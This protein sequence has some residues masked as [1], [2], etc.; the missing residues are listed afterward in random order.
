MGKYLIFDLETEVVEARKRK[1]SCFISEN[2]IVARGWK[3]QGDLQC[4]WEYFHNAFTSEKAHLKIGPE[5]TML[6]GFNLKFD[7][8]W[9]M[10]RGNP[11]L[12]EFYKRGGKIWD[13]QYAE[14]LIEGQT[15]ASQMC[16]LD[17]IV[18]KYGGRKKIDQVKILW[19]AG[20]KTAD[21]P[22]D[23]LI[24]YLVGTE[25]ELRNSGDIGNTELIFLAQVQIAAKQ[26]Q[27]KMI[28]DRMD[29][30]LATTEME[31][32]GIK[33]DIPVM[34]ARLKVLEADLKVRDE[35]LNAFIPKLDFDFSWG[36]PTHKS[37]LIFGGTIKY[38]LQRPY[39]DETGA[40]A[41][42]KTTAQWPLVAGRAISPEDFAANGWDQDTYSSGVKKGQPKFKKVDVEGPLKVK[43]QDYFYTFPGVTE[44]KPEWKLALTDGKGGPLYSTSEEVTDEITI[45]DIPFLKAMGA[46]QSLDKEIGT[47]YVRIHPKKKIPVGMLAVVQP[48][49]HILHHKLNHTL[50]VTTRLS[51]SEPNM[52]NI[53]QT[54]KSEVK[55]GFVSRFTK[56][57][58][59]KYGI[60]YIETDDGIKVGVMIEA[61]YSQLEVVVQGVL[62]GD[63]ALCA[64]LRAK[65]DFHCKRVSAKYG[66]TYED[67]LLWCKDENFPDYKLW[68]NR[69]TGV[70]EF[71]FQRAYG[72]G[73]AAIAH[74]TGIPVED[75]KAM[76]EAEEILY[77]GV[78]NFNSRVDKV[79]TLSSVPFQKCNKEGKWSTYHRGK[80]VSPTG[81]IYTFETHDAPAFLRKRGIQDSY[82]PPE[83]KNYPV[84]G[85][86]GEFVQAILGLLWRKFI[87]TDNYG[88]LA[89]LV[90]TVHDCVWIDCH[91]SV[92]DRVAADV[93]RIMQ[94]VPEFYNNR[95]GM[96]INVPFPVEVEYG[97]NMYEMHHWQE[98]A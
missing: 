80:W 26:G 17:S 95:H 49:D 24:D 68:K 53:P 30:L 85:T 23:L 57:Y 43:Y 66:C 11:E 84:Q 81:T 52:Q 7:L 75:I 18:E 70:K 62:S 44:P 15:D 86:G 64:D 36:S 20:T 73:A 61:D 96:H 33:I 90:N 8:M 56:A 32:R 3:V 4:S 94:S 88:G 58:C 74:T 98:A 60:P 5:V 38:E 46:K 63:E 40:W 55:K 45:R 89:F 83:L 35:E 31:F 27:I 77:P 69:R 79:V 12:S 28:Q 87:E 48:W 39:R 67:A 54:N 9:E 78:V 50:T 13:C 21:I 51:S 34:A 59:E 47:Y 71:S 76:I 93:K 92:L 14:Y 25:E 16:S 42:K 1:A 19:E 41:R 97:N 6:V 72:A 82:S 22:E 37:C 29:G 91:R 65:I 10:S 2:Y